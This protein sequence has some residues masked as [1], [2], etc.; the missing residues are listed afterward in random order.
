MSISGVRA[1][2]MA[3]SALQSGDDKRLAL[4]VALLRKSLDS[5]KEQTADLLRLM[6]GKGQVV[7]LRV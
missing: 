6:E 7:D 5:Q 3:L 4:Q 2:E 1:T